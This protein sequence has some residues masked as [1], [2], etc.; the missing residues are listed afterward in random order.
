MSRPKGAPQLVIVSTGEV[1]ATG[2]GAQVASAAEQGFH[3]GL[4]LA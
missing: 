4:A 2:D 3:T 1:D